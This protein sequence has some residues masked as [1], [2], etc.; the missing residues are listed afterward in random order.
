MKQALA[1]SFTYEIDVEVTEKSKYLAVGVFD[2]V[3]RTYGLQR[4]DL[5]LSK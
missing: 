1:T 4:V 3:G 2:E 5:A